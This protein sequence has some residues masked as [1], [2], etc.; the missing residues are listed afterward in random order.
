MGQTNSEL[1]I[2]FRKISSILLHMYYKI[3]INL[4]K[5]SN[6]QRVVLYPGELNVQRRFLGGIETSCFK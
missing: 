3:L 4:T 5:Y 2:S 1:Q 6:E